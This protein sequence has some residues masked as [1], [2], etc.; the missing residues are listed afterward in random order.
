MFFTLVHFDKARSI[1]VNT[2]SIRFFQDGFGKI[3]TL[4]RLEWNRQKM[5]K[6]IRKRKVT[7]WVV[8]ICTV[9]VTYYE[10]LL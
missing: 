9:F 1:I 4:L 5:V 6:K 10:C 3:Q 8:M 7:C 2:W